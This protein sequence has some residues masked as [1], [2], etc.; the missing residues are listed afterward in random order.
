MKTGKTKV[1]NRSL[2]DIQVAISRMTYVMLDQSLQEEER[3]AGIC[4]PKSA[5]MIGGNKYYGF[6]SEGFLSPNTL[7]SP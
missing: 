5:T 1:L 4:Q 3:S 2:R 6:N 7:R